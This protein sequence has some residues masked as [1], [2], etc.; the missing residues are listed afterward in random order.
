MVVR[1]RDDLSFGEWG[2]AIM[3]GFLWLIP[4]T[5]GSD[6]SLYRAES[7]L[8]PIVI[9]LVRLRPPVLAVF[10]V[11]CVPVAYKMAQLFFDATLI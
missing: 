10:A 9:L 4:L 5:L 6:L 1:Y 8:L 11:V 2:T 3:C 7:L